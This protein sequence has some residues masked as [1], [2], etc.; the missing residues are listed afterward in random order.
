MWDRDGSRGYTVWLRPGETDDGSEPLSR[1]A[2]EGFILRSPAMSPRSTHLT[3]ALGW[4]S[5]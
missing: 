2:W 3:S 4:S 1:R 5:L